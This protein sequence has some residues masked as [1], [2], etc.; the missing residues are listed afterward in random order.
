MQVALVSHQRS[1]EDQGLFGTPFVA[2]QL[3]DLVFGWKE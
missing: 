1:K 2:K 3:H